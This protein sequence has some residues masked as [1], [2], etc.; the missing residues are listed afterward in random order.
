[1]LQ[2]LIRVHCWAGGNAAAQQRAAT[3][4]SP[5]PSMCAHEGQVLLQLLSG[6]ACPAGEAQHSFTGHYIQQARPGGMLHDE[7]AK[8]GHLALKCEPLHG[9]ACELE[10]GLPQVMPYCTGDVPCFCSLSPA[11]ILS[12]VSGS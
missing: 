1:M 8:P 6:A 7:A 12:P 2:A 10:G 5:P 11:C 3:S 4:L 9:L